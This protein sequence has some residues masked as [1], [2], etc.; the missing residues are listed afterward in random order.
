M[1]CSWQF[2][3][4]LNNKMWD[5]TVAIGTLL[6]VLCSVIYFGKK[7]NNRKTKNTVPQGTVLLHQRPPNANVINASPFS[8]KLETYLRMAKIP[9]ESNYDA[10]NV[11]SKGKQPWIQLN[12]TSVADSNFCIR[13]LNK[14]FKMNLES[15]LSST[16]RAIVHCVLTTLEEN[17][18]W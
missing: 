10:M 18:S 8:L 15:H 13:F 7:R 12:G 2:R 3:G 6:I 14:E 17:T 1:F 16:E 4:L 11:S 5:F 9:Y